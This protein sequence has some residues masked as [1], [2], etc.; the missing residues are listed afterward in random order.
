VTS[1]PI[2]IGLRVFVA[3]LFVAV[4]DTHPTSAQEASGRT[5]NASVS[6]CFKKNACV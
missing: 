3:H 1:C 4:L 2:A 5:D 6:P